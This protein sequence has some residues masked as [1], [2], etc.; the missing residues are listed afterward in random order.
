MR[1]E[2]NSILRFAGTIILF[3]GSIAFFQTPNNAAI[4]ANAKPEQRGLASGILNLSRT[5]GQTTGMAFLGAIFYFF[6]HTRT[7]AK[8]K[9][10]NIVSGMDKAIFISGFA[11]IFAFVIGLF[12]LLKKSNEDEGVDK[13]LTRKDA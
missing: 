4:I 1:K 6:A 3:N 7:V 2:Y 11:L 5:I 13:L 10:V 12:T 9:P 8:M